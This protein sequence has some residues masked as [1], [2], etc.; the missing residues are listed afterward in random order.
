[1]KTNPGNSDPR[2]PHAR[3]R[4]QVGQI[5]EAAGFVQPW[6]ISRDLEGFGAA[7]QKTLTQGNAKFS[8]NREVGFIFQAFDDA[9]GPQ[10]AGDA[11]QTFK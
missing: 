5:T 8:C 9:S 7:P 10:C 2:D 3:L 1:M 6:R 4:V 11:D